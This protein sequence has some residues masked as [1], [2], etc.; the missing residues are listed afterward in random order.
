MRAKPGPFRRRIP[1]ATRLE[2]L[3]VPPD[4]FA[5]VQLSKGGCSGTARRGRRG[6]DQVYTIALTRAYRSRYCDPPYPLNAQHLSPEARV[7]GT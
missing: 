1:P 2:A 3:T 4:W 6:S 5:A 7:T